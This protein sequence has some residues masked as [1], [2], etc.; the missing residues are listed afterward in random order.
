MAI[1]CA[2]YSS[3]GSS[4]KGFVKEAYALEAALRE[5]GEQ[6]EIITRATARDVTMVIQDPRFRWVY[7]IGDGTLS[8]L[9]LGPKTTPP[10]PDHVYSWRDVSE[11]TTHLKDLYIQRQSGIQQRHLNV[12]FGLFGVQDPRG[13]CAPF[14]IDF[15]PNGLDDPSNSLISSVL[16]AQATIQDIRDLPTLSP[17]PWIRYY[18]QSPPRAA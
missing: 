7:T 12:P 3:E 16:G 6:S 5:A 8:S 13:V 18:Q 2:G 9:I 1:I 17:D 11:A 4:V 10:N 15:N 14:G